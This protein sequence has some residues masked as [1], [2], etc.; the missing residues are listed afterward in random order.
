M[1]NR[2]HQIRYKKKKRSNVKREKKILPDVNFETRIKLLS[3]STVYEATKGVE[4]CITFTLYTEKGEIKFP[5]CN[6]FFAVSNYHVLCS[7]TG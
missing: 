5:V 2:R 7:I 4:C 3:S 1:V 6:I